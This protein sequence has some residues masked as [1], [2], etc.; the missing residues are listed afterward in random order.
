MSSANGWLAACLNL[1]DLCLPR[2]ISQQTVLCAHGTKPVCITKVGNRGRPPRTS[3]SGAGKC[4]QFL[5]YRI[6]AICCQTSPEGLALEVGL[7]GQ[8]GYPL[9]ETDIQTL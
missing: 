1:A 8:R 9:P 3:A 5:L 4:K 6:T 2:S 7:M